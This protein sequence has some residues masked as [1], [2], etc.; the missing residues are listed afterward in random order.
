M[1]QTS[2]GL[3]KTCSKNPELQVT[4]VFGT[5]AGLRHERVILVAVE[6]S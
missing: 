5:T 3:N 4:L 2:P 6:T 1:L